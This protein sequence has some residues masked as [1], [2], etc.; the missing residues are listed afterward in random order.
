MR[1][2]RM[3]KRIVLC[4][5]V[6]PHDALP[7]ENNEHRDEANGRRSAPMTDVT[8]TATIKTA[9]R[10]RQMTSVRRRVERAPRSSSGRPA[11]IVFITLFLESFRVKIA[12]QLL[13][14]VDESGAWA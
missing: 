5:A 1:G 7:P 9:R 11:I 8:T 2:S 14:A 6:K 12:R 3:S 13:Q 4:A 10:T